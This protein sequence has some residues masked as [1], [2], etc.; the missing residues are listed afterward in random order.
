MFGLNE[1]DLWMEMQLLQFDNYMR[2]NISLIMKNI[3]DSWHQS[4][5]AIFQL[6][7]ALNNRPSQAASYSWASNI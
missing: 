4:P 7:P 2:V 3:S 6:W 1:F 5:F